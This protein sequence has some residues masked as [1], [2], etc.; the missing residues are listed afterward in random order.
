[1]NAEMKIALENSA[2]LN[3]LSLKHFTSGVHPAM[4]FIYETRWTTQILLTDMK[5]D[6]M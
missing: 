1:M 3:I 6:I 5:M 4:A 2:E